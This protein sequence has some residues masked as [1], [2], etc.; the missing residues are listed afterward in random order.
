MSASSRDIEPNS[1]NTYPYQ[2]QRGLQTASPSL[3][4]QFSYLKL[5]KLNIIR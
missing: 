4:A 5:W 2:H 1:Q 3:P